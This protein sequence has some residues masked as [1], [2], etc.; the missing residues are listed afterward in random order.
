MQTRRAFL[1]DLLA[2]VGV[3]TCAASYWGD[4]RAKK[5][6]NKLKDVAPEL[7]QSNQAGVPESLERNA[8]DASFYKHT[9]VTAP[10]AFVGSYLVLNNG[11]RAEVLH[12][13]TNEQL[14]D[15]EPE[16]LPPRFR[17][18]GQFDDG[19]TRRDFNERA[20]RGLFFGMAAGL[21]SYFFGSGKG[22]AE[23]VHGEPSESDPRAQYE[24]SV[25]KDQAGLRNTAI[26][27]AGVGGLFYLLGKSEGSHEAYVDK[28]MAISKAKISDL[29]NTA[30]TNGEATIIANFVEAGFDIKGIVPVES[31]SNGDLI[32][33]SINRQEPDRED[34]R[35][36]SFSLVNKDGKASILNLSGSYR[37]EPFTINNGDEITFKYSKS[38]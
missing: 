2:R 23:V 4:N 30:K 12:G 5:T 34:K 3:A 1:G 33:V 10:V 24:Q 16:K 27:S 29:I 11:L 15:I 31:I 18:V 14:A 25:T 28:C 36:I 38:A 19:L 13:A 8:Y 20:G 9:A 37:D 35:L 21:V 32:G 22:V 26:T 17:N 6:I 7:A